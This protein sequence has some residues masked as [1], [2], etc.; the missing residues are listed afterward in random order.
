M[1][2]KLSCLILLLGLCGCG[3][4][5]ESI[6]EYLDTRTGVTVTS[7][8][9]PLILYRENPSVAAH[10][11]N[12]IH[13]GPIEINRSGSYRYYL[14]IGVWNTMEAPVSTTQRDG[15]DSLTIFADGEPLFLELAG[16]THAD[17]GTS[18]SAYSK[19]VASATDAYYPVTVDQ[20]RLIAEAR[21]IRVRTTGS[22]AREYSLW[23]EQQAARASFDAFLREAFF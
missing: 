8:V 1:P 18:I 6:N 5:A 14:W 20:I 4:S 2:N 22:S 19:P 12:Y 9:T 13:M 7:S 17:I 23:N 11:R 10:A 16:F 21:E 3:T 15:F